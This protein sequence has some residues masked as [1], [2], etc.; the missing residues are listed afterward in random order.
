MLKPGRTGTGLPA[1]PVE[2]TE[3][4]E[5]RLVGLVSEEDLHAFETLY[6]VYFP[7]LARFLGRMTRSAHLIEEIVN[8]TMLVIWQKADTFNGSSKVSTWV[9]AI[10]Y[11]K[12][13]KAIR[14]FDDPV[15][16]DHDER[17]ALDADEPEHQ[18][19]RQQVHK[20]LTRAL[21]GLPLEQR[22]VVNL[23]YYHGMGYE[24][25]AE[26]MDCPVNTVKTRMFHARRRMKTVLSPHVEE[27]R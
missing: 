1:A 22:N 25:I 24:E 18:L 15:E 26:V 5:V 14:A 11:R 6:R 4:M 10:A 20:M 23:A 16:F 2:A 27:M 7:R 9:F 8:D 12:A 19:N 13:M 21:D 3:A 17:P